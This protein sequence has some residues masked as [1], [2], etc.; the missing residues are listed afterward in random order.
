MRRL[1]IAPPLFASL[2][3]AGPAGAAEVVWDGHYRAEAHLYDSLSLSKINTN[4]E[5]SSAWFDHK[6]RLRPGF[7]M[8]DK[9]GLYTQLDLL[10]WVMW[11][12]DPAGGVDVTTGDA[13]PLVYDQS[14]TSPTTTDGAATLQNLRLSRLWGEAYFHNVGTLRFGRMPVE[15][16][17]GLVWNAG[18]DPGDDAGDT[19]DRL[20]F[21]GKA[22]PVHV[23]GAFG[24]PYG[25]LVNAGDDM[26]SISGSVAHLAE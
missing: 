6:A 9:V 16:G 17:S 18:N 19:E 11:G 14:V 3:L 23:M 4:A 22:G 2:L 26:R 5:G 13:L 21:T 24:V 7:L 12:Q 1:T 20:S 25:G 8:S 10:P 15:W